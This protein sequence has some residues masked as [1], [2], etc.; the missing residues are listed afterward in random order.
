[1]RTCTCIQYAI[2]ICAHAHCAHTRTR[3]TSE[4]IS[5]PFEQEERQPGGADVV[6]KAL[7]KLGYS[8]SAV[9]M[10]MR[11]FHLPQARQ[12]VYILGV[13]DSELDPSRDIAEFKTDTHM[14]LEAF[15]S[16]PP[17]QAAG[18]HGQRQDKLAHSKDGLKYMAKH[19]A[20]ASQN[21][22]DKLD[23]FDKR[24]KEV[25]KMSLVGMVT[26]EKHATVLKYGALKAKG[27][28]P[29]KEL[30]V[31]GVSQE[32]DRLPAQRGITPTLTP[33]TRYWLST[34]QRF[35]SGM[36]V[37]ALQGVSHHD[38]QETGLCNFPD[39]LLRDVGGN[40]FSCP[41]VVVCVLC[42]LADWA[43]PH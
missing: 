7:R 3:A 31:L 2:H 37:V 43:A 19:D 22:L 26:R 4:Q 20:F 9:E 18:S 24:E 8:V 40:A 15:L 36:E 39:A 27:V 6:L 11:E 29:L 42:L 12:R 38:Q 1:M 5:G 28:D 41:A 21:G 35:L 14:P 30:V 32:V 23:T 33:K 13:L 25:S 34:K 16:P 17:N 10:D